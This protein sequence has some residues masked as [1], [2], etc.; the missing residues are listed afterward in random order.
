MRRHIQL[1]GS[2]IPKAP[3]PNDGEAPTTNPGATPA[4]AGPGALPSRSR[5][6]HEDSSTVTRPRSGSGAVIGGEDEDGA[7]IAAQ[8]GTGGGAGAVK[9]T[10]GASLFASAAEIEADGGAGAA[11]IP[12]AAAVADEIVASRGDATAR[13]PVAATSVRGEPREEGRA[14]RGDA[15]ATAKRPAF[16]P[17]PSAAVPAAATRSAFVD[18][19]AGE[20]RP[21]SVA[22][23]KATM[24]APPTRTAGEGAAAVTAVK[25]SAV[26]AAAPGAAATAGARGGRPPPAIGSLLSS[27]SGDDDA[28]SLVR[29]APAKPNRGAQEEAP[30]LLFKPT[31]PDVLPTTRR[32]EVSAAVV[33]GAAASTDGAAATSSAP[34]AATSGASDS[35]AAAREPEGWGAGEAL[36]V[37][38]IAASKREAVGASEPASR[39]EAVA[40]TLVAASRSEAVAASEAAAPVATGAGEADDGEVE[41]ETGEEDAAS[42]ADRPGEEDALIGLVIDERYRLE[43]V[44]GVGAMSRVYQATHVRSGGRLAVKIAEM[45]PSQRPEMVKRSV[46]EVRAM[47]EIQSNHVV[48]ALDV[49][50]FPTGQLYVVM[51]LLA[52]ETLEELIEREGPQPWSRVGPMALQ[53]CNGLSAG[54]RRGIFHRDIKP[55]N[56][57][58]VDL[59]DNADHIKL[60]DFGLARDINGEPGV[61]QEGVL[62]GSPET[63]A[64]ELISAKSTPDARSD[65]YSLGATLYKLLT[66]RAPF[67]G[68]ANAID[69]LSHPKHAPP[70]PPSQV[71]PDREIPEIADGIVMR[72]LARDP[73]QRFAT[74]EELADVLRVAF[75]K[76]R[77]IPPGMSERPR[78]PPQQVFVDP[79]AAPSLIDT[80]PAEAEVEVETEAAPAAE[81][82]TFQPRTVVRAAEASEA[83]PFAW[84]RAALLLL[85]LGVVVVV[86][87]KFMLPAGPGPDEARRAAEAGGVAQAGVPTKTDPAP[88]APPPPPKDTAGEPESAAEDPEDPPATT[89]TRKKPEANFDYRSARKYVEE[90]HGFL[91]QTCMKK[92]KKPLTQLKFRVEVRP[93]GRAKVE[94]PGDAAVRTCVRSALAFTFDAS[95]RG[96]AFQYTLTA[97]T[98]KLVKRPL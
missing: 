12:G 10:P 73:G 68:E 7:S 98:A 34:V 66:G 60:I 54:H 2:R 56:C 14:P 80:M 48:R 83:R 13:A 22:P 6:T 96:G 52:G 1:P 38:L 5:P 94:V 65:I 8:S 62:L 59:D 71:A 91:R 40:A 23:A 45:H 61:T 72:A 51:E 78:T 77:T 64:P 3:A 90:Q 11:K 25:P 47:M 95:P 4:R 42:E 43:K 53:I 88:T 63:M 57:M 93:N 39:S 31:L 81:A 32:H 86:A 9:P 17:E 21:G 55:A 18:D 49:G 58:R 37:T 41:V 50:T 44:I 30:T 26:V 15:T 84:Q 27:L 16:L 87:V 28:T 70:R 76:P 74:A 46:Q 69:T 82:A 67:A 89:S 29:G 19:D 97:T 36:A 24:F 20:R 33:A 85:V 75:G 35:A 79:G 92:G